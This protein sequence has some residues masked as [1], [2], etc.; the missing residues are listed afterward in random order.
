MMKY[1]GDIHRGVCAGDCF[2]II[3]INQFKLVDGEK[4]WKDVSDEV[5]KEVT[6]I[7]GSKYGEKWLEHRINSNTFV[8][9]QF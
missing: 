8:V 7:R 5:A 3:T 1:E 6:K 2:D 4:E 9:N